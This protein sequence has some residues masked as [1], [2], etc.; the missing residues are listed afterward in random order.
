MSYA[1]R[2]NKGRPKSK[3]ARSATRKTA[4][5]KKGYNAALRVTT[6]AVSQAN[7]KKAMFAALGKKHKDMVKG[8]S[9]AAMEFRA[10]VRD[11]AWDKAAGKGARDAS[12][13]SRPKRKKAASS[14]KK[15][16]STRRASSSRSGGVTKKFRKATGGYGYMVD[17]K[18]ASKEAYEEATGGSSPSRKR[19]ASPKKRRAAPKRKASSSRKKA[20]SSR[21]RT[22]SSKKAKKFRKAT[23]GWGYMVGGKFASAAAYEKATGGSSRR[24]KKAAPKR[25]KR[26]APRRRANPFGAEFLFI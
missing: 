4:A 26:S 23:G 10:G 17:G 13:S 18:F 19:K 3:A 16:T 12:V 20:S 15:S 21:K 11:A 9:A 5:Y 25:A 6:K 24:K 14:R 2:S 22:A 7:I 8:D 1:L